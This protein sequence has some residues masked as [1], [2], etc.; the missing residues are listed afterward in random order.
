MNSKDFDTQITSYAD[1]G[2]KYGFE[3]DIKSERP[4]KGINEKIIKFISDKKNEP[5]WML[6]LRLKSKVIQ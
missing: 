3:T 2:Y 4:E 6:N 5:E 1:E